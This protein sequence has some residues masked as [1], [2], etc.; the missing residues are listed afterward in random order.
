NTVRIRRR[1]DTAPAANRIDSYS[2]VVGIDL[3]DGKSPDRPL[4]ER[5]A[6]QDIEVAV[7]ARR[8]D[9]LHSA[10]IEWRRRAAEVDVFQVVRVLPV[11]EHLERLR[12]EREER[13]RV[14]NL[15]CRALAVAGG[16]I[17]P[18]FVFHDRDAAPEGSALLSGI[19]QRL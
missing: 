6:P 11:V 8:R 1:G 2:R 19:D 16:C 3:R 10:S 18:V 17:D 4:A 7:L 12:I 14:R 9:E 5:V 15:A 13:L